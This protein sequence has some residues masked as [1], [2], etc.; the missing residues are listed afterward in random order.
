[1]EVVRNDMKKMG[2]VAMDAQGQGKTKE[3]CMVNTKT[4]P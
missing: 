4:W 3:S 1:M 2:F